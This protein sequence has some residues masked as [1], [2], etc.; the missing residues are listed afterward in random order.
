MKQNWKT[1]VKTT[2]ADNP[3]RKGSLS[4]DGKIKT[5]FEQDVKVSQSWI[6]Y[7]DLRILGK[8]EQGAEVWYDIEYQIRQLYEL[9]TGE[10][11]KN[12]P[13]QEIQESS[14]FCVEDGGWVFKRSEKL[15]W[16]RNKLQKI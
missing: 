9:K 8:R 10:P 6:D 3:S 13:W 5:S 16:D 12:P 11:I 15:N 7:K 14:C 1:I 2:A 4:E